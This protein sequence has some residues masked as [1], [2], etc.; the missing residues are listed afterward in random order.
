MGQNVLETVPPTLSLSMT[1]FYHCRTPRDVTFW[2]ERE[3]VQHHKRL[4]WR[5]NK[6]WAQEGD[7][8]SCGK[9]LYLSQHYVICHLYCTSVVASSE[10]LKTVLLFVSIGAFTHLCLWYIPHFE[11]PHPSVALYEALPDQKSDEIS[12]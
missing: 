8:P 3:T 1:S 4:H 10:H 2:Q 11:N 9:F 7:L 12:I 6:N 5:H